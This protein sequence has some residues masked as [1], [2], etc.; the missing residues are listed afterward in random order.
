MEDDKKMQFKKFTQG[1]TFKI[2]LLI[3]LSLLLLIPISMIKA[4]IYERNRTATEAEEG[5]M[6]AWGS[7]LA[8]AGPVIAIP[9]VKTSEAVPKPTATAKKSRLLK[10]HL[11]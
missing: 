1:Y 11:R 9:G 10:R 3:M 8:E 5:I 2:L 6:E 7:R 4:L